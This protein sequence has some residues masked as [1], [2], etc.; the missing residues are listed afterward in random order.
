MAV[1]SF[2]IECLGLVEYWSLLFLLFPLSERFPY[3]LPFC[4]NSSLYLIILVEWLHKFE[5]I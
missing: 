4:F 5:S 1:D 2:M 3:S